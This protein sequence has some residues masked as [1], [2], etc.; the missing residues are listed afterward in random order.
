MFHLK[1]Y[2]LSLIQGQRLLMSQVVALLPFILL[3][4]ATNAIPRR[5]RTVRY[6]CNIYVS[7]DILADE[8]AT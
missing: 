3:N 7:K 6:R 5:D 2:F 1:K 8:D 4:P